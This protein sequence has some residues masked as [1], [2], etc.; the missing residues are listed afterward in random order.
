MGTLRLRHSKAF[1]KYQRSLCNCTNDPQ[2]ENP[3]INLWD[4]IALNLSG[5]E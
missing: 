4:A 1:P 5:S 3:C 2:S